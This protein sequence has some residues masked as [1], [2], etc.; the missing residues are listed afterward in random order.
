[1]DSGRRP[2]VSVFMVV[3]MSINEKKIGNYST[4]HLKTKNTVVKKG[5]VCCPSD[6]NHKRMR[7]LSTH[8]NCKLVDF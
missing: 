7:P 3:C 5:P 1:M 6:L 4:Q 8:N 2:F